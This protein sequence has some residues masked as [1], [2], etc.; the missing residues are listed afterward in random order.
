MNDRE[1][2]RSYVDRYITYQLEV[3]AK[4][5]KND[6]LK[7]VADTL[8]NYGQ[9]FHPSFKP[10]Y[11]ATLIYCTNLKGTNKAERLKDLK[12]HSGK[13]KARSVAA[14]QKAGHLDENINV[15]P[16]GLQVIN[17]LLTPTNKEYKKKNYVSGEIDPVSPWSKV[18]FPEFSQRYLY[19]AAQLKKKS[20]NYSPE[21]KKLTG[22]E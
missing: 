2:I 13:N 7:I 17:E 22:L 11:L 6:I 15:T 12:R 14:L 5:L 3:A 8:Q 1:E 4:R 20:Q 21:Y 16:A 19:E 18:M 10:V 9:A